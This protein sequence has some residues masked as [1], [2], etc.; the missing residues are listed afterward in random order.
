MVLK[1]GFAS[2]LGVHQTDVWDFYRK[3]WNSETILVDKVFYGWQF[4]QPPSNCQKDSCVVALKD[5]KVVGAMGLNRRDFI[6]QNKTLA[7]A[8]LTTW[9]VDKSLKNR[10]IGA[11]ILQFIL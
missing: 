11:K 4:F 2:I 9:V 3:N 1:I 6:Y 10:G 8:E 7:G 5:N